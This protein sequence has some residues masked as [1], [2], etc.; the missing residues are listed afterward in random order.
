MSLTPLTALSPVDGRYAARC[1][2]LREIFSE[3]GLIRARVRVEIAWLQALAGERRIAELRGIT[4]ADLAVAQQ[5]AEGFG[6]ADAATVKAFERET[7]HDVKAVEYLVKQK[8]GA[9]PAWQSRLEFVHFACTSEDINNLSYALMCREARVQ[10]AAAAH[11]RAARRPALDGA[12][13]RR[14]RDDVAHARPARDAH[15]A[16][17]GSRGVRT[18]PAP[19][20]RHVRSRADPR[21][22]QRR[23]RQLQ[24]ARGGLPRRRLAAA[25]SAAGRI[26][27]PGM[28]PVHD[29]DRAARLDR[30]VLRRPRPLQLDPHDLCRDFWGYVSLGYFRQKVVAGE[31]GSSTMPHKVNPIDFENAEGNFGL[32]NALLR[33]PGREAADLALAA[34]PHRLHRAAQPGRRARAFRHR[35]PVRLHADSRASKSTV[36]DSPT[37]SRRTGN[38][39]PNR[40]RP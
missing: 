20:A 13:P 5:I 25:R 34:R 38:C 32:A 40:S 37:I 11:R 28:E 15:D 30:G 2:D 4:P 22:D 8:L 35:D 10:G 36:R 18:P 21:Q 16:R 19:G 33:I 3:Q 29:A 26:A 1:A 9:H 14:R 17:Q 27:R 23:R 7:N 31:V 12:R 6:P 24:C 39:S